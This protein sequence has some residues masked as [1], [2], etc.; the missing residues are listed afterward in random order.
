MSETSRA[1]FMKILL[2]D[3]FLEINLSLV[4]KILSIHGSFCQIPFSDIILAT[5]DIP[6]S[7][8]KDIRMPGTNLGFFRAGTYFTPRDGNFGTSMQKNQTT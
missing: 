7:S 6:K 5:N 2:Y 1:E 4:E 8:W 3:F